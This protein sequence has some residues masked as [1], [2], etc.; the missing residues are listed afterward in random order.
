MEKSYENSRLD[1]KDRWEIFYQEQK[2][3]WRGMGKLEDFIMHS[4][5]KVLDLG[6]GNGKTVATLIGMDMDVTGLDFSPSAIDYCNRTYG[7]K[8]KFSIGE[9]EKLPFLDNSFDAVTAVHVFEHLDND[10][11]IA[12][13]SEIRRVLVPG[14]KVFVRSFGIGDARSDGKDSNVRGNGICYKYFTLEEMFSIFKNFEEISSRCKD[15]T[16]RYGA[17]RVKIECIFQNLKD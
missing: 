3:P 2:R 5:S 15:E 6:C 12:T 8:A 16:M 1:Q 4:G 14:G 17:I 7:N 9:C 10:Q 11:V 13:V